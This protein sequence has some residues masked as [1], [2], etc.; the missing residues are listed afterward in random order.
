M[1][2]GDVSVLLLGLGP[3]SALAGAAKSLRASTVSRTVH[4]RINSATCCAILYQ[5]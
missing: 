2:M 5:G 3:K 1:Y 4:L